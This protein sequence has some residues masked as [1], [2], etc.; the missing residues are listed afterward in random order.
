M[1]AVGATLGAYDLWYDATTVA[2]DLVVECWISHGPHAGDPTFDPLPGDQVRVGDDE[3]RPLSAR[4]IRRQ[5][6][7]V[8][9][10]LQIGSTD[11]AV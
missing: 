5:Q 10:R 1:V 8:T 6:D 2:A 4:V 11:Q 7:Q 3:E 9:V